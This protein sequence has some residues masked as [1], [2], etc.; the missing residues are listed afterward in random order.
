MNSDESGVGGQ[1]SGASTTN[2]DPR[3]PISDSRSSLPPLRVL[4]LM[5]GTS[6]DGVD[7]VLA[8]L[9]YREGRMLWEVVERRSL[10]YSGGLRERLH[11][12]L[13]P[14]TSDVVLLTQLHTEVGQVYAELSTQFSGPEL[15]ALSGQ[16]VYHIPRL[17]ASRGWQTVSTLQLGE[18]SIVAEAGGVP[19]L[20]DFRQADMAAGGQGA[21]MVAFGDW[22][23]YREVGRTRAIHNL[24]GISNLT[25][26]PADGKP[27]GVIA[28]DTGPANCLIDE[29]AQR[30]F[31]RACDEGGKLAA[32]GQVDGAVLN[33]LMRHPYLQ[34]EPPK[35]TGREV[36]NLAE[37]DKQVD[38]AQL[39][40]N[41]VLATLTAFTVASIAHAY[42]HF[43]IP[44]GLQDVLVAGGGAL[45]PTLMHML[46][47]RLAVP[48]T[49]FEEQ[50]W[51]STDREA[52]SFAVMGY[53]A[54]HGLPNTLPAATGA[55]RA[56]VAGKLSRNGEA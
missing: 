5:S 12:A 9:E 16:T 35:T 21:P 53:F 43:I 10:S 20:S 46:R 30:Y 52:L 26:L 24:G 47:E 40:P 2:A 27:A 1:G 44:K 17:E 19:V 50:G 4:G 6:L 49:T 14:E 11:C 23:L 42:E 32:A 45:N 38:L 31:G 33:A 56:V 7:G 39:S 54:F 41:D 51:A 36:F 13:K 15:I 48:A 37:I 29:A 25:Y 3:S 28:F 34:L 18:A 22:Q 8:R 55:R